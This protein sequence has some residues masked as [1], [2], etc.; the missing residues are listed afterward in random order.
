MFYSAGPGFT[1]TTN[2]VVKSRQC[3]KTFRYNKLVRLTNK[4]YHAW[5]NQGKLTEGEGYGCPSN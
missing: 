4:L 5:T 3:Y 2:S 1:E